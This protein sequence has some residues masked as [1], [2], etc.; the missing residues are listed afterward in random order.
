MNHISRLLFEA[1]RLRNSV[2]EILKGEEMS[3]GH[4]VSSESTGP[5][6]PKKC[7]PTLR[8]KA[9]LR[10]YR[11]M[12]ANNAFIR[13]YFLEGRVALRGTLRFP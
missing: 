9:V 2:S 7:H 3:G 5:G 4:I 10:D 13:P 12:V 8:N 6:T 11:V 1:S